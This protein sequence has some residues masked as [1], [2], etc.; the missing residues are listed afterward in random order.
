[1]NNYIIIFISLFVISIL[2]LWIIINREM[3]FSDDLREVG[4]KIPNATNTFCLNIYEFELKQLAKKSIS[5]YTQKR[6]STY[7]EMLENKRN[8]FNTK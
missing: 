1:M 5:H 6:I 3:K 7:M 4:K 8:T 2:G